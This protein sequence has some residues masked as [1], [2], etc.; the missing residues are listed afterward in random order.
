VKAERAHDHG[1]FHFIHYLKSCPKTNA[2]FVAVKIVEKAS[3]RTMAL[4]MEETKV[5]TFEI[6]F[7][8]IFSV[9]R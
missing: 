8:Q 4:W 2:L 3:I 7:S 6:F 5:W 9:I 1:V